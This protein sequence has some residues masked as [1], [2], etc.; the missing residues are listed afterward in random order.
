MFGVLYIGLG[1]K[2]YSEKVQAY[3]PGSLIVLPAIRFI[4]IWQKPVNT[5]PK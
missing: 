3:P 5:S 1:E 4:S 2:P